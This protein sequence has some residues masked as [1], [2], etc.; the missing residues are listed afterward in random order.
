MFD[1]ATKNVINRYKDIDEKINSSKVPKTKTDTPYYLLNHKDNRPDTELFSESDEEVIG[2]DT[3][4]FEGYPILLTYSTSYKNVGIT[5]EYTDTFKLNNVDVNNKDKEHFYLSKDDFLH[6]L[7]SDLAKENTNVWYNI[8]YD[9]DV[10][11][12]TLSNKDRYELNV[13]GTTVLEDSEGNE[14]SIMVIPDKALLIED[15]EDDSNNSTAYHFDV[16]QFFYSSLE[17]AVN[18]WLDKSKEDDFIDNLNVSTQE[19]WN[20]INL[21]LNNW[22]NVVKYGKKDSKLVRKLW[23]KFV[24]VGEGGEIKIPLKNPYSSGSV[25]GSFLY[26]KLK[27]NSEVQHKNKSFPTEYWSSSRRKYDDKRIDKKHITV[28]KLSWDSY[29]G[30]RFEVFKK[31]DVGTVTIPDINSAYPDKMAELPNPKTLGWSNIHHSSLTIDKLRKADYGIIQVKVT[32]NPNK[33]I[34][35]FGV[36]T[37][38]NIL[39]FP[40]IKNRTITTI[41]PIFLYAYDNG[42]IKDYEFVN[43]SVL[44]FETD[45][46]EY[47]YKFIRDVYRKRKELER[48]DSDR[49]TKRAKL[50]KIVLNSMYGKTIQTVPDVKHKDRVDTVLD[51]YKIPKDFG[52]KEYITNWVGVKMKES[53]L[54]EQVR[55]T[56]LGQDLV[57]TLHTGKM[58]NP[59]LATHITGLTRLQLQKA[60]EKYDLIDETIAFATDSVMI[61]YKA[62]QESNFDEL[63]KEGLGNWDYDLKKG[64]GFV[65]GS[66][67]YEV[68]GKDKT[69]LGIRGFSKKKVSEKGLKNLAFKNRDNKYIPITNKRPVTYSETIW[70][71]N[72]KMEDIADFQDFVKEIYVNMDKKR[73]WDELDNFG[74]LLT[75]E[76]KSEPI[77]YD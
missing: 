24:S 27:E 77:V 59:F 18:N 20:D 33:K 3:E 36:K 45:D 74:W 15:L 35:P 76:Y 12:K 4:T 61:D 63:I 41:L 11:F 8:S 52:W 13:T 64:E 50:L 40:I 22:E 67:I 9:T 38:D 32:T 57:K 14:Y 19:F 34:Q 58:F 31:G 2:W 10:F 60:V 54:P 72:K 71:D 25:A 17:K 44:G 68:E 49:D 69:K 66:G 42:Y 26:K 30:G 51:E 62:F 5:S 53:Q 7:C 56:E 65:V 70:N 55:Y 46:T 75:N 39:K 73:E 28:N 37:S 47:P 6:N 48:N 23:E 16:S 29:K 43:S 21:I 1:K